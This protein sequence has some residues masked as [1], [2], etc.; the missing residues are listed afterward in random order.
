MVFKS[1]E[2]LKRFGSGLI[3]VV[4]LLGSLGLATDI[5]VGDRT[6]LRLGNYEIYIV[7]HD[8]NMTQ[9]ANLLSEELTNEVIKLRSESD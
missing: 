5:T 2:G 1:S 4:V 7:N 9:R 3:I 8:L 6:S